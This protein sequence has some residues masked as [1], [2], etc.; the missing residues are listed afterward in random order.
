MTFQGVLFQIS[1]S[2]FR[3]VTLRFPDFSGKIVN[4]PVKMGD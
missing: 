3:V 2:D 1:G 4:N